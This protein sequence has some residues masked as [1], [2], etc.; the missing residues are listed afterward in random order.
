MK[1]RMPKPPGSNRFNS[2][3]RGGLNSLKHKALKT[4]HFDNAPES[5]LGA[6]GRA[7]KSPRPDQ[8]F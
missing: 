5:V 2:L 4:G 6:G 3:Q 8:R 7:F 1:M